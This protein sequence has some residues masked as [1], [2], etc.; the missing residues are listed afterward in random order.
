MPYQSIETKY[1]GATDH[2]GSRIQARCGDVTIT[3]PYDYEANTNEAVHRVAVSALLAREGWQDDSW[4]AGI[5]RSGYV[6]VRVPKQPTEVLAETLREI[7][8]PPSDPDEPWSPDTIEAVA[9]ELTLAGYG[10]P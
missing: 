1:L 10:R 7:L 4:T 9:G 5:S 8:W 6:F 3:V 2:R